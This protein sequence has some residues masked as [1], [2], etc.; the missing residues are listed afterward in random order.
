M[1]ELRLYHRALGDVTR[2]R[3]VHVLATGGDQTVGA[4]MHAARVSQP[5]MSWH[6]RR[7]R[8]AGLVRTE[9]RG[10]EVVCALDRERFGELQRRSF[11]VLMN[12]S[13][14]TAGE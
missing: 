4:L 11:R 7:L 8:R 3:I 9:R 6:L 10:R 2:L 1:R 5:L 13:E 12:P 14:A